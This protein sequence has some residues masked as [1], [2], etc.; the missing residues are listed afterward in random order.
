MSGMAAG[1]W[2]MSG[3][4]AS[5][6]VAAGTPA[7]Q[8]AVNFQR[9]IPVRYEVDVFVAGGGPAGTAAAVSARKQNASV[10]LAEAHTCL[11]GMGTA[12][13]VPVFM[14]LTDGVHFL[15]G[16]FGQEV[17]SRLKSETHVRGSATDIEA[18]KRVYDAL[19]T[20]SGAKFSFY[21]SLIGVEVKDGRVLHVICSAPSGL[22]A[23]RAKAYVDATG[24]GDLAAWAG[25]PFEKGDAQG[26]L[27]PGTLC[28]VWTDIDWATV[29]ANRAKGPQPDGQMLEKAFADSV[30]TVRD[31][32][33][34]GMYPMGE[35][36]GRG[37]IGHTFDVD[38]NDEVSLTKAMVWG[39]KSLL[40]Y[41]RYYRE[42]LKGYENM[43]LVGTGSLLGVR[44]TRRIM[45]DYVL[46]LDDYNRR[47]TFPDEIGRYSYSVD[48]HPLH[49]GKDTYAQHRK[50]FDEKY[51]YKKG[52]SYGIPYRILTPRKLDNVLVAGRCVSADQIVHGSLRVMPGCYI[53]GQAAGVAAAMVAQKSTSSHAVDVKDLQARL[54]QLGG[55]LPNA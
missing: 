46:S 52:E 51:R 49:P 1:A 50:E 42:Y 41:E 36:M 21:T 3:S 20:E 28:S 14:P 11:G 27:M 22:F 44:E 25:A 29:K 54:K 16:G 2:A 4:S 30:F 6:A 19:V 33:L 9:T 26:R 37:N 7:G 32:H 43:R 45:G 5:T 47:A 53:T 23:V 39:R 24:N 12:A 15:P 10:F 17:I 34:T 48:I 38:A 8:E 31:E 55:Y 13:M 18:L 40:E 35:R